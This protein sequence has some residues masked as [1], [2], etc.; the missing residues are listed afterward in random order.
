MLG[1][2]GNRVSASVPD[3]EAQQHLISKMPSV[4]EVLAVCVELRAEAK[5]YEVL[6]VQASNLRL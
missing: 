4:D 6:R 3:N 1:T 5:R 2:W